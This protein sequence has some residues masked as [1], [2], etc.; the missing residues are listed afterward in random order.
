MKIFVYCLLFSGLIA[1]KGENKLE[2]SA[3]EIDA[4]VDEKLGD[5]QLY[6]VSQSL[7]FSHEAETYEV[8][9][10]MQNDTVILYME[11]IDSD[12]E[13]VVR[14]LFYKDGLLIFVDEL[15]ARNR[16]NNPF[17]QRKLYLDGDV[18]VEAYEREANLEADLEFVDYKLVE[19]DQDGYDFSTPDRAMNQ[20]GE[21]D[22]KFEEIMQIGDQRYLV[23]ENSIS[24]YDV[25]LFLT[26]MTPFIAEL[27][28]NSAVHKGRS[29][30]VTHQFILMN[31]IERML[32]VE[33]KFKDES[34]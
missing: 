14:Q 2:I 22:L 31:S 15:I 10:F 11:T 34:N 25:A 24:K 32:F 7:R 8:V 26:E 1:C 19:V 33:G 21:F 12:D 3:N 5:D 17:I 16:I 30:F 29:I 18:I 23:L 20:E 6:D 13:Q 27:E 9:K 4:Y 28:A